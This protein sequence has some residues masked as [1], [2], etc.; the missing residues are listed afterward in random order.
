MLTKHGV[1]FGFYIGKPPAFAVME[2]YDSIPKALLGLVGYLPLYIINLPIS[3]PLFVLGHVLY[4]CK[5]FPISRVSN[6]W[7]R[8]Y[9]RST[10]HTS[11]V[12]ILVPLLQ[13]SIFEE[14]ITESL[15]QMFIQIINNSFTNIW[16]PLSYFSTA[17]SGI[18]ILNGMWRLV[19]Y[20]LY[21]KIAIDAI[22]T[23]LSDEIFKF[24]SI[25]EGTH[26]I[27]KLSEVKPQTLELNRI[28][29]HLS[30]AGEFSDEF[31][32]LIKRHISA[33]IAELR[34][35]METQKVEI[36]SELRREA[37]AYEERLKQDMV[38]LD[39]QLK[40]ESAGSKTQMLAFELQLQESN[41]RAQRLDE[42]LQSLSSRT[43]SV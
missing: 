27:G 25:E 38:A 42:Q 35:E 28:A 4:C 20:R 11:S 24:S 15:P 39:N 26:P 9:T 7:L 16:S 6:V 37:V 17:M 21:L 1:N 12:V 2:K 8:L 5:V 43:D 13:Q 36:L 34:V 22:P 32:P 33:S 29:S 40:E 23:P 19:Y 31:S 30:E 3:L 10:K 41:Q 18:M 14:M